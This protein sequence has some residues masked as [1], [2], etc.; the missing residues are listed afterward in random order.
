MFVGIA[1]LW[2]KPLFGCIQVTEDESNGG[3]LL[4]VSNQYALLLHYMSTSAQNAHLLYVGELSLWVN[5][6]RLHDH[7]TIQVVVCPVLSFLLSIPFAL[8]YC[9]SI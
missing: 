8:V 5:C 4:S 3:K 9:L 1:Y 2:L 7:A 6:C